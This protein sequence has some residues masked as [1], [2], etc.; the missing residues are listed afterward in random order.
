MQIKKDEQVRDENQQIYAAIETDTQRLTNMIKDTW[1]QGKFKKVRRKSLDNF[2]LVPN[3]LEEKK[4]ASSSPIRPIGQKKLFAN[5][6]NM[7]GKRQDIHGR[8]VFKTTECE[9][10]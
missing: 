6:V 8:Q 3:Q 1:Q 4:S 2:E 7:S 9:P 5:S 10:I